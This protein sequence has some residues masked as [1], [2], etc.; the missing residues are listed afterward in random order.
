MAKN[1]SLLKK[2]GN[3][4]ERF[5]QAIV[6]YWPYY[7][8]MLFPAII[9]IIYKIVPLY[10]LQIAFKEYYPRVG[11]LESEWVGFA[12]F[13]K[14]FSGT[15]F[16]RVFANTLK[17]NF[18]KILFGFPTPILL[19]LAFNAISGKIFQRTTQIIS[20]I[21][22]F[23]SWVIVYG[24]MYMLFNYNY[25]AFNLVLEK[26]G[27]E[28]VPF[29]A[30]EKWIVPMLIFSYVW[31]NVGWGSI[32]YFAALGNIDAEYYEAA[33][34]DGASKWSKLIY[35][36]LPLLMPTMTLMFLIQIGTLLYGD[37]EQN[38]IFM[39]NS[40]LLRDKGEILETYMYNLG[41]GN[42]QYSFATAVGIFQSVFGATLVIISNFLTKRVNGYSIW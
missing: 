1:T 18:L 13:K 14:F 9:I 35:I 32:V 38:L 17:L 25:G 24:F 31:K 23:L 8:M 29:L 20:Y 40:S 36:T 33:D 41:I 2:K 15:D 3:I 19:A 4:F 37:F 5:I 11:I 6:K 28:K 22:Q 12:H 27:L 7:L 42:Q 34:I 10:G 39:G 16:L 30:S 26:L 21:P